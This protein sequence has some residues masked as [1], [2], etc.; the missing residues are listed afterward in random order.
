[1]PRRSDLWLALVAVLAAGALVAVRDA[2]AR[3]AGERARD[4][5]R[6]AVREF[7]LADLCLTT[8]ARYT[9]HPAQADRFAP[10][11]DL[12]G[13]FEYAPSGAWM[14]PPPVPRRPAP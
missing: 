8:E 6:A 2:A 9:R 3:R 5:A 1:M 12:P 14:P 10:F 11:Q 7:G 13:A 4:T